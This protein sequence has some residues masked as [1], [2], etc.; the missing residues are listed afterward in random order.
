MDLVGFRRFRWLSLRL[1]RRNHCWR[2]SR[3][4]CRRCGSGRVRWFR[5]RTGGERWSLGSRFWRRL[6]GTRGG[7]GW[8]EARGL[9][10]KW[11]IL[12]RIQSCCGRWQLP[13]C[14]TPVRSAG[15]GRSPVPTRTGYR[16]LLLGWWAGVG[17]TVAMALSPLLTLGLHFVPFF[18]LGRVEE[19]ADLRVAALADFHHFGVAI[20][21]GK[22]IVLMQALH[23]GVFG[24]EDFLHFGLLIG[25]EVEFLAQFLGALGGVGRAVVPATVGLLIVGRAILSCRE[26]RG[27]RDEAGREKNEKALLEHGDLLFKTS[28][29]Q[30]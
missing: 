16:V 23:L 5:W 11:K 22:R 2:R 29:Q 4:S 17:R 20:L 13:S 30:V 28:C 1:Q 14:S 6:G 10:Q 27:D 18:L 3:P 12:S 7:S 24:L 26:R 21:L 9:F 8:G 25:C 15:T 19:R